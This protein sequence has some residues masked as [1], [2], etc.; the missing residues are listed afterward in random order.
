MSDP[1]A[2]HLIEP[3]QIKVTDPVIAVKPVLTRLTHGKDGVKYNW[4]YPF[5]EGVYSR[6]QAARGQFALLD[7]NSVGHRPIFEQMIKAKPPVML[8]SIDGMWHKMLNSG[9]PDV[10]SLVGQVHGAQTN[11]L[12]YVQGQIKGGS[13]HYEFLPGVPRGL[14]FV[15]PGMQVYAYY[16]TDSPRP[17]REEV[18][19]W[20]RMKI[21]ETQGLLDQAAT[22]PTMNSTAARTVVLSEAM[23]E[24]SAALGDLY[25]GEDGYPDVEAINAHLVEAEKGIYTSQKEMQSHQ[26]WRPK[27]DSAGKPKAKPK[28]KAKAK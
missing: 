28:A 16:L 24:A 13:D 23:N 11:L 19:E 25:Y 18:D 17:L 7:E 12:Q 10:A 2:Y 15:P 21:N 3:D 5:E 9:I 27:P 22:Q 8:T 26:L 1:N 14:E 20:L 4:I 6:D